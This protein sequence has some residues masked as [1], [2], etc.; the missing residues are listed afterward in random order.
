MEMNRYQFWGYLDP[1][2]ILNFDQY[3]LKSND[4]IS[5]GSVFS[6]SV[7][8]LLDKNNVVVT[9]ETEH[10][11]DKELETLK[12]SLEYFTN[13][14]LGACNY[15]YGTFVKCRIIQGGNNAKQLYSFLPKNRSLFDN[16]KS[17]PFTPQEIAEISLKDLQIARAIGQA[18]DALNHPIDTGFFC[19]RSLEALRQNFIPQGV[20]DDDEARLKSW[21]DMGE[22]LKVRLS[23]IKLIKDNAGVT[24]HGKVQNVSGSEIQEMIDTTWKIIDRYLVY[25]RRGKKPL[26]SSFNF[27]N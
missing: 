9:V 16:Q 4:I 25:I 21:K 15:N 18:V 7:E 23:Y 19:Y 13:N 11:F 5:L 2:D 12:N 17:R 22:A 20:G 24:R 8:V 6:G 10:N 3:T 27:L 14:F 26:D 1:P